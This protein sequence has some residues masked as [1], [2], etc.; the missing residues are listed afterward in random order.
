MKQGKVTIT[1]FTDPV[2]TWCWGS[3]P[4]LRTLETHFPGQIALRYVM[5][6]LVEN[7]NHF[8][9]ASNDIGSS[10]MAETNQQI[11]KHWLEAAQRHGMPVEGKNF[12]LF[13]QDY[14]S[15][16]PQNIAYKAAQQSDPEKADLFLRRMR[17]ATAVEAQVTGREDVLISLAAEV[18]LNIPLFIASLKD[19]SA[20]QAFLRDLELT[21]SLGVRGFPTF[22]VA[23]GDKQIMLRGYN[24]YPAFAAVIT[25]LSSGQLQPVPPKKTAKA[26]LALLEKHPRLAM[27]EIRMAYDFDELQEARAWVAQLADENQLVITPA[28]NGEFV[29]RKTASH[30]LNCDIETGRCE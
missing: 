23:Y 25:A 13:S 16:Y 17:E 9:D 20:E 11:V 30:G 6:G 15:T 1:N 12:A 14:P 3:E 8:R 28:G 10:S 4:V 29:S 19:G 7:V 2:C 27:E 21:R 24:T 5:G 22:M 26:L 18:G